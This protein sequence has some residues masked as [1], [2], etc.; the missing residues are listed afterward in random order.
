MNN[1]D[2][3]FKDALESHVE[4]YNPQAW[5]SLSKRLD[6]GIPPRQNPFIKWGLPSAVIV[7][8]I[9][10]GTW[11]ITQSEGSTKKPD[12]PVKAKTQQNQKVAGS[13][14]QKF[15][16]EEKASNTDAKVNIK[17]IAISSVQKELSNLATLK[18]SNINLGVIDKAVNSNIPSNIVAANNDVSPSQLLPTMDISPSSESIQPKSP[19]NLSEFASLT[20]PSCESES[21]TFENKN[22]FSL[23]V[24]GIHEKSTSSFTIPAKSN[25]AIQIKPGSYEV[26]NASNGS[27]LQTF[28]VGQQPMVEIYTED[29][30]YSTGLPIMN[31]KIKTES[32]VKEVQ[33]NG[34]SIGNN[35]KD[36][37]LPFFHE[38]SQVLSVKVWNE[39][40]CV[41][42][43]EERF[44]I[45]DKYNLLAVNAF[46]PLSQDPRKNT[47]LPYAL[48][49]RNTAFKM[50]IID[51]SDGGV[52]F[53]TRD[54]SLPWEGIDKRTGQLIN[55]NKA[56]AWKVL[57]SN[58]EPG[59]KA[60]Y[61][62]TIV[63]M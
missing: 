15:A 11:F 3:I 19:T 36:L 10:A 23:K 31:F 1:I 4:P 46:E 59:E 6:K 29:L 40:G 18:S 20:V 34:K 58:P 57:L 12:A 63:R 32:S 9:A 17:D 42:N 24:N 54:A 43:S 56:Y 60:E 38:G 41:Q 47:F 55:A 14:L 44:Y 25:S 8:G 51:P 22:E 13:P 16:A 53:E 27:V 35:G 61:M 37:S 49:I 2:D 48:T 28:N 5:E 50:I 7:L 52:V 21:F 26:L 45:Q 33:L 30:N 39:K 62:G